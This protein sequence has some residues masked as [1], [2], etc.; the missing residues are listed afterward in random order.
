MITVDDAKKNEIVDRL[1]LTQTHSQAVPEGIEV[2]NRYLK[3]D[4]FRELVAIA[5]GESLEL[6]MS[7]LDG[8]VVLRLREH[9]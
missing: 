9:P 1:S 5:D 7:G 2:V 8:P 3:T 4:Q 6:F